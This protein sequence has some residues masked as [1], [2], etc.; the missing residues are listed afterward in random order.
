MRMFMTSVLLQFH[1]LVERAL[2]YLSEIIT[3]Q[4]RSFKLII[5]RLFLISPICMQQ[6][7]KHGDT[8][9]TW[10][11]QSFSINFAGDPGSIEIDQYSFSPGPHSLTITYNT[12]SG[13]Q[14]T[15]QYN[16]TGLLRPRELYILYCYV[17]NISVS[18]G[19]HT[20]DTNQEVIFVLLCNEKYFLDDHFSYIVHV[21][22]SDW[23]LGWCS[24]LVLIQ[25]LRYIKDWDSARACND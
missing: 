1:Q 13:E 20:R 7:T 23:V 9:T 11:R 2:G 6:L 10:T 16:F 12:T 18:M 22:V 14:G 3:F 21:I 19:M 15:F 4:L 25:L 5:K 24:V 17:C 8:H